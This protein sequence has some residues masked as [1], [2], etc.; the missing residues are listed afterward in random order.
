VYRIPV[1]ELSSDHPESL[2]ACAAG[3]DRS[4]PPDVGLDQASWPFRSDRA[5]RV[6][7]SNWDVV[8]ILP[9]IPFTIYG[10]EIAEITI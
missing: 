8:E 6:M 10:K 1:Q 5:A 4:L 9:W 7:L 2:W 3:S